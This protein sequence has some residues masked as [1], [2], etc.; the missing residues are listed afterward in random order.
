MRARK[1]PTVHAGHIIYAI[2][3][4]YD[5]FRNQMMT[6]YEVGG[7]RADLVMISKSGYLTEFEIKISRSDWAAD[8]HKAKWRKPRPY[9]KRFFY[10]LPLELTAEI[11]DWVRPEAGIIGVHLSE[12]GLPHMRLVRAARPQRAQPMPE[13]ARRRLLESAYYRFWRAWMSGAR[14]RWWTPPSPLETST[15]TP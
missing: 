9:V 2:A 14:N 8:A 15:F 3:H 13:P 1:S 4:S 6:E 10:A 5:W 11:P 7:G 12:R